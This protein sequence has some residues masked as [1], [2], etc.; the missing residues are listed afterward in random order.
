VPFDERSKGF[1][2][3]FSFFAYFSELEP[4][5]GKE[6]ILLL[7]E[8]GLS[9]H[10]TAQSDFLSFIDGRLAERHQVIYSTHSPFMIQADKLERV[11]T[12]EDFDD[13]GTKVSSDVL[14]VDSATVFPLQAALGYDLAQT[15][16]LGPDCLLV[17]GPSDL[18]YLQL[19]T[20]A[21]EADGR[22][23]LDE[24][25]V[26]TPAGGATNLGTFISLLGS[27][28]L[29]L[30]VLMDS[31]ES[32]SQ[33]VRNL[34][35][36]RRITNRSIVLMDK[37]TQNEEADIEDLF[38]PSF[39]LSLVNGAYGGDL[40]AAIKVG[41]LGQGPRIVPRV[42]RYFADNAIGN[43]HFNHYRPARFFLEEQAKLIGKV[44][45]ATLDRAESLFNAIDQLLH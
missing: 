7:D 40:S 44:N 11:R 19:L 25:W 14:A 42:E 16:F 37:F 23:G 8:P 27:N 12:V 34:L 21:L 22:D 13:E 4:G 10:A 39:Y 36:S 9:L 45:A 1:V 17:E 18:L 3:F 33:R 35:A 31:Q 38:E 5:D 43:G 32:N 6:V 24:R 15:L 26:I 20:S 30:A 29:N 2:W 28:Q 41:D